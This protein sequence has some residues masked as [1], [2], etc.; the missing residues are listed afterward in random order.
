MRGTDRAVDVAADGERDARR[1]L[2]AVLVGD[3]QVGVRLL[4]LVGEVER[5]VRA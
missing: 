5:V 2:A 1:F 3:D 4:G